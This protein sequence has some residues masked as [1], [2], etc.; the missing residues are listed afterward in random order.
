M[1]TIKKIS[2]LLLITLFTIS[3]ADDESPMMPVDGED[4]MAQFT[5]IGSFVDAGHT[6]EI[7]T[8]QQ[9]L[10]VGY[11]PIFIRIKDNATGAFLSDAEMTWMPVMDMGNMQHSTPHS[12]LNNDTEPTIY[13]GYIVFTMAS[14][15]MMKWEITFTYQYQGQT[16]EETHEF[17]VIQPADGLV[18]YQSFEGSDSS[19]YY[20]A[21]VAPQTP[22][23]GT[24][25]FKA[26]L[27]KMEGMMDFSI[28]QDYTI[29]VDPRMPDMGNHTSP[30]NVDLS[31]NPDTEMYEGDLSLTMTGFW[32]INLQLLAPDGTVLAG[33]AISPTQ[34]ESSLYFE[35]QL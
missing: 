15:D 30:N 8:N 28:P 32:R 27:F 14:M 11:N 34:S 3:C 18:Q 23:I 22:E 10:E 13:Q 20:L 26:V 4:P 29:T 17:D 5:L 24:N 6:L 21:Y 33:E 9:T 35:L 2:F 25:D 12:A 31:Y 19:H 16:V 7:Y 1:K